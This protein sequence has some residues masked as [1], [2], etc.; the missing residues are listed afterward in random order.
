MNKYGAKKTIIDGIKFASIAES[1]RYSELLLLQRAGQI[2]SL[3]LQPRY[4]LQPKFSKGSTKYRCIE[5]VA[6]FA[7]YDVKKGYEVIEDVK[8]FSNKIFLLKQ[9]MFEYKYPEL[10]L[11]IVK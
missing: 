5:Y 8:G 1:R 7:Y 4:T 3:R 9:K 2:E 6:D 11:T 10:N